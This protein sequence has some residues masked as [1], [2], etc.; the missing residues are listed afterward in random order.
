MDVDLGETRKV[1]QRHPQ[2]RWHKPPVCCHDED[3]RVERGRWTGKR[4]GVGQLSTEIEARDKAEHGTDWRALSRPELLRNPEHRDRVKE[5]AR[6][7][8][9]KARG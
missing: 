2:R 5:Q 8:T 4:F 9:V 7:L 3:A 6:S 1:V